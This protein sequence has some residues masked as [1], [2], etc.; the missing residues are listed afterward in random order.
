MDWKQYIIV[1]PKIHHGKACIK[2]TR[3]PV[4]VI[5]DNLAAG[6]QADEIIMRY[7]TLT[8][9]A[10]QAAISYAADLAR[11]ELIVLPA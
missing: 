2:N 3:I 9:P 1:D 5:L 7:P 4:A 6:L 11:E 8:L 10:I